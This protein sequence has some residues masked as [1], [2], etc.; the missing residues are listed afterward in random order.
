M[1][2]AAAWDTVPVLVPVA[3]G[4]E[5]PCEGTCWAGEVYCCS[6]DRKGPTAFTSARETRQVLMGL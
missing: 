2:G 3:L 5:N 6:E 1:G 4:A